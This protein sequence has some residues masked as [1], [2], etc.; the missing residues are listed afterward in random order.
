MRSPHL[1]QGSNSANVRRYNERLLLKTLRRAGSA[2]KADLARLANLTGTAVG[3]IIA[4]LAEAKLI[5]FAGRRAEGQRGQPASLIRLDPRGAFGIG[6]RL[7]RMRIETA[8]V[9]FAGDV[10][11]RRSHDTLLP[12]PAAV[13]EIV[14]EDVAAMQQLLCAHERARLTGVGVAQPYNLGSWLR[15]I[16]LPA[17]AFGAWAEVDFARELDRAI[18]L[19]VFSENDGNAAAIAE[20]FYGCGRQRDDFVYLFLGPAI[21]GGIAVDGDCLR[22][23]TGN[24][25][26]F[27]MMPVPPSRL[28]S[29]PKPSGAWDLLITRA[30]LNGLARHL[31]HRGET[32]ESRADLEA[33]IARGGQAVDEWIDDC[34]DALAPAL[35]AVLAVLESPVVVLDADT[36]AGLIDTLIARLHTALAALAPEARGTPVLVRGTFGP[37]AGAI[38]AATLPMFFNFSPRAGIL[39]GAGVDS[40]EARYAAF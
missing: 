29:V 38:G 31:R 8:L 14:R 25:G 11:G 15:E 10:I 9:N 22:G 13:L 17:D 16:D 20:L 7:D 19:P 12:Q 6:V 35:R 2:S 27:A 30:S 33:C 4:S 5:E 1:G 26:D 24:A 40:Q 36:D 3:S 18:E 28:P 21:G 23:V 37:D 39:R 34:V 32:L